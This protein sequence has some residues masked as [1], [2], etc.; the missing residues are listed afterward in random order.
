MILYY[1]SIAKNTINM[2][3]C[4]NNYRGSVCLYEV[5]HIFFTGLI[6]VYGDPYVMTDYV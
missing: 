4:E 6:P 3:V 2:T 1:F 5:L